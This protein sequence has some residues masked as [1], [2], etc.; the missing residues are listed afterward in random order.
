MNFKDSELYWFFPRLKFKIEM[1]FDRFRERCQRFMRGYSYGDVWNMDC[2]FIDTVKPMLIHLRDYG[3]GVP[4]TLW[5]EE[6]DSR[7]Y[8]EA[9]LTEMIDSLT[10]MDEDNVYEY[11]FGEEWYEMDLD[12]NDYKLIHDTMNNNKTRFFALFNKYFYNLWD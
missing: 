12:Y 5:N 3:C 9:V 8:W 4:G 10:L 7:K 1:A 2:W 11:L 6:E